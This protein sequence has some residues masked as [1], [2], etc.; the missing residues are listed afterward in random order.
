MQRFETA[1]EII[2][3]GISNT[4]FMGLDKLHLHM[5]RELT[6]TVEFITTSV[7]TVID[8]V[9]NKACMNASCIIVTLKLAVMVTTCSYNGYHKNDDND[10]CYTNI[11][12]L[13]RNI[14]LVCVLSVST[15]QFLCSRIF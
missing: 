7:R 2:T 3:T 1:R 8:T 4:F 13:R 14:F 11:L 12:I 15:F 6:C 9:T 10:D 5:I